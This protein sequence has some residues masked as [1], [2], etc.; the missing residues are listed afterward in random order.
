MMITTIPAPKD[1]EYNK[2]VEGICHKK[3][4][5]AAPVIV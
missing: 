1:T 2:I 5:Q 4:T 3:N